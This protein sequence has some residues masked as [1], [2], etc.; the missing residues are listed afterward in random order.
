L[1]R[2]LVDLFDLWMS[3]QR[4]EIDPS[5]MIECFRRYLAHDGLCVSRAEFE[6]NLSGKLANPEFA[7][8]LRTLLAIGV[9]WSCA[10]ARRYILEEFAPLLPG[11][12]WKGPG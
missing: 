9:E 12:S 8:D 1:S 3:A 7:A 4:I 11:K 5:R 6:K 2:A 10:E